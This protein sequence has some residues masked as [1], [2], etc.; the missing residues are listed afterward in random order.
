MSA[1]QEDTT[2][3][4]KKS[5]TKKTTS[6]TFG[7]QSFRSPPRQSK[8][9]K[10]KEE[11]YASLA[12]TLPPAAGRASL[13]SRTDAKSR[14]YMMRKKDNILAHDTPAK[15]LNK[16]SSQR[17]LE[18]T[19]RKRE[20]RIEPFKSIP[21]AQALDFI[22][23]AMVDFEPQFEEDSDDEENKDMFGTMM[24]CPENE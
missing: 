7:D 19:T 22:L 10:T 20:K 13:G 15:S 12:A 24:K 5:M 9:E 8:L 3:R 17:K 4:A 6:K 23:Q 14:S 16:N 18:T 21:Q 11:N 2:P 1:K